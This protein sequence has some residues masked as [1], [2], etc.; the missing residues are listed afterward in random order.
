M[1]VCQNVPL[2]LPEH[3]R[4]LGITGRRKR[5]ETYTIHKKQKYFRLYLREN[6]LRGAPPKPQ[7][8]SRC[9]YL[10]F[11]RQ[12]EYV[13]SILVRSGIDLEKPQIR[14]SK[15]YHNL[16][17]QTKVTQIHQEPRAHL[18]DTSA[19]FRSIR[20]SRNTL[21]RHFGAKTLPEPL[22]KVPKNYSSQF[23]Y[24]S[25]NHPD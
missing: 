15:H 20:V 3:D 6:T 22:R 2:Y 4:K 21:G 17:I 25:K 12:F 24:P 1:S 23:C 18:G 9:Y 19:H 10:L 7:Q 5:K 14:Q 13:Q 16:G 11:P 8:S